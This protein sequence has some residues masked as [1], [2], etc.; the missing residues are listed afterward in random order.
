MATST[1]RLQLLKPAIDD[2]VNVVTQLDNNFDIIDTNIGAQ[3]CTTSTRPGSPY[4]G[5]QIF[6]TDI[7]AVCIWD[8]VNSKWV[9][10]NSTVKSNEVATLETLT[11][12]NVFSNLTTVGPSV[13]I[14]AHKGQTFE[15]SIGLR[16]FNSVQASGHSA[17]VG[18][19]ISGTETIAAST[20]HCVETLITS[21]ITQS[22]TF[23]YT[24][25]N[26]EGNRTI[27]CKYR[28]NTSTDTATFLF[29]TL[30]VRAGS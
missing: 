1:T 9:Q 8:S 11:G 2:T 21:D 16:M 12:N 13:T 28:I 25:N 5:Q 20:S 14:Y 17:Q 6:E 27:T 18:F 3:P 26:V 24:A 29:R 7:G 30:V 10:T 19:D 23:T 15:I 4:P 22:K